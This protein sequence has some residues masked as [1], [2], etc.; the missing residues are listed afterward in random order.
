[1]RQSADEADGIGDDR[2]DSVA[3]VTLA[4]RRV[5]GG[6]KLVGG[7]GTGPGRRVEQRRLPRVRIADQR[8]R[9]AIAAGTGAAPRAPLAFEL[10]EPRA[11]LLDANADHAPVEFDLLLARAAGL[12]EPTAL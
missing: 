12:A 7:V 5:E 10:L 3:E 9:E 8:H 6:E 4:R 2:A 11:Q 1:M